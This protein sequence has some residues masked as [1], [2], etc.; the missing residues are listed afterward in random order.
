MTARQQWSVVAAIVAVLGVGLFVASRTMAN[1]IPDVNSGSNA[2][3]FRAKVLNEA[4]YKTL[5]DYKGQ[6]VLLNI[7]AT[8]C[9]PCRAELPSLEALY[10]E[11][12]G[13][14]LKL[15]AISI[16]ETV[17]EDSIRKFANNFGLTFEILHD[18][19]GNIEAK[20]QT[21]GY[22]MTFIIGPEGT[23]R[24]KWLGPDN[25]TSQGNRALI[26]QLLGVETP[27]V[28]GDTKVSTPLPVAGVEGAVDSTG[29]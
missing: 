9:P 19:T 2:P 26:A 4:K 24:R 3:D 14:G 25:W 6:V 23:I 8:W 17:S 28:V 16:D 7:W 1:Q 10:K 15:V 27:R 5:A 20:Y 29:R 18:P 12:G 21:T 13:K 11:Y 22:P